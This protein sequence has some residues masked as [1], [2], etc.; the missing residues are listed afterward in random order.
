[1]ASCRPQQQM[2]F[3]PKFEPCKVSSLQP[4]FCGIIFS[5]TKTTHLDNQ[6][7]LQPSNQKYRLYTRHKYV[8]QLAPY[9][10]TDQLTVNKQKSVN[11]SVHFHR[12]FWMCLLGCT[13]TSGTH[14]GSYPKF[15]LHTHNTYHVTFTHPVDCT[16]WVAVTPL[17]PIWVADL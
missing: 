15:T 10:D 7:G 5:T 6:V 1:M 11:K 16:R 4:I 8:Q 17:A 14:L 9:K 12:Q 3:P 2:V 13:H